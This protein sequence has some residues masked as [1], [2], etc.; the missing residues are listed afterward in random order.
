MNMNKTIR[1]G[2]DIGSTTIKCVVL[3]ENGQI[4]SSAYERHCSH[5]IEKA[6]ELLTKFCN[7]CIPDGKAILTI[8]G[9]AGIGLADQCGLSFVQEVYA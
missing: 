4:L 9:S 5:I 1:I 3:N 8:S 2:M 7:T 6:Q